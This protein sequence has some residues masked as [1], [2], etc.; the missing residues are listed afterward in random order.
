MKVCNDCGRSASGGARG[1]CKSCHSRRWRLARRGDADAWTRVLPRPARAVKVRAAKVAAPSSAA[2]AGD[3][4]RFVS[5]EV[6]GGGRCPYRG[7]HRPKLDERCPP[8][9]RAVTVECEE[10][11]L[12]PGYRALRTIL[13]PVVGGYCTVCIRQNIREE[14]LR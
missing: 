3:D 10:P 1:L 7:V 12:R 2:G 8:V 5:T 11:S 14:E 6:I 13:V 9:V 4:V